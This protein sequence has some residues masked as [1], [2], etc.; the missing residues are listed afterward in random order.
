[1][2]ITE[3][4]RKLS[5]SAYWQNIYKMSKE[6][7]NVSVFNNTSEFSAFQSNFLYWLR[8]YDM[9]YSELSQK[10]WIYLSENVIENN[11]RCD[12]FLYY[13]KR[14]IEEKIQKNKIEDSKNRIKTSGKHKGDVTPWEVDM[15]G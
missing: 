13:R 2:N 1:M 15:R 11:F 9:L 12:A 10:E 3:F 7:A 5:R 14:Q 8:I 4:I 6:C